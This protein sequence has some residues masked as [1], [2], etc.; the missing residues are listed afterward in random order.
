M[1]TTVT[2]TETVVNG[3]AIITITSVTTNQDGS[4]TTTSNSS[5]PYT[6]SQIAN[7]VSQQASQTAINTARLTA[8]NDALADSSLV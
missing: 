5:A 4:V 3:K 2:A 6:R 8:L 7:Q 1:S